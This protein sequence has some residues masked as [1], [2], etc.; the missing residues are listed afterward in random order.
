MVLILLNVV[1]L[2]ALDL[3]LFQFSQLVMKRFQV[4]QEAALLFSLYPYV[5]FPWIADSPSSRM[6]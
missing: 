3:V 2:F 5:L 6:V 4:P 1:S